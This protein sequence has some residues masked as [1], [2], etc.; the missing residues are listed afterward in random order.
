M[1]FLPEE[2]VREIGSDSEEEDEAEEYARW[3][4]ENAAGDDDDDGDY[5]PID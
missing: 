4:R 3:I 5:N 2:P 1:V